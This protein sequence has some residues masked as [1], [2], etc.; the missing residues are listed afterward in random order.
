VQPTYCTT[1]CIAVSPPRCW[2]PAARHTVSSL[3]DENTVE[4]QGPTAEPS[5]GMSPI[6]EPHSLRSAHS[7]AKR[8]PF[9]S[10]VVVWLVPLKNQFG[11]RRIRDVEEG[12]AAIFRYGMQNLRGATSITS[13][14]IWTEAWVSLADAS[15]S[16]ESI[17]IAQARAALVR[18]AMRVEALA[19]P[20]ELSELSA[21]GWDFAP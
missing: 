7:I 16:A 13:R 10:P 1:N 6:R 15:R 5:C 14:H 17:L 21:N 2:P 8:T 18:A 4:L 19:S 9:S 12:R 3:S 11:V 20:D